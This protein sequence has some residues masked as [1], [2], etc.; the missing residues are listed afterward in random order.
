VGRNFPDLEGVSVM[1]AYD[2]FTRADPLFQRAWRH[3]A[4]TGSGFEVRDNGNPWLLP[5][6]I[7]FFVA[8][9]GLFCLAKGM[10]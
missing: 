8:M 9:A 10:G 3:R 6:S 7:A 1:D 2:S 4:N 5:L